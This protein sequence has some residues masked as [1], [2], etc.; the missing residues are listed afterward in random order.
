MIIKCHEVKKLMCSNGGNTTV[1]ENWTTYPETKCLEL[2]SM[3]IKCQKVNKLLCFYEWAVSNL[4]RS[5]HSLKL[6]SMIIKC[7]KVNKLVCSIVRNTVVE[8]LTTC[9]EIKSLELGS[10]IIKLHKNIS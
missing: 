3:I 8:Y 2:G 5:I 7:Q 9:P 1:L 4:N 10:M 6:C